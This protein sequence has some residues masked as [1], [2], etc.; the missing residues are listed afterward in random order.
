MR[1]LMIAAV[2]FAPLETVEAEL[3]GSPPSLYVS[4]G[5]CP[6]ECCTYREW[7]ANRDLVLTDHPDGKPIA[8][9]RKHEVVSAL[10]GEAP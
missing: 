10:A 2:L 4:K 7:T 1:L 5:A 8:R 6:F 9:F 3:P